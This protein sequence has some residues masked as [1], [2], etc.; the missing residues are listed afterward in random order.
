MTPPA[1][2][3]TQLPHPRSALHRDTPQIM[4]STTHHQKGTAMNSTGQHTTPRSATGLVTLLAAFLCFAG[5]GASLALPASAGAFASLEG[6]PKFSAAPGLPDGREYVQV[7]PADKNG[8]EAGAST[9]VV[10]TGAVDHYGLASTDGNAV[11]FEGTGPMGESPSGANKWF[12]ATK[13]A[14]E[15]GWSTRSLLPAVES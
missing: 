8:N 4:S 12:V 1:F 6:P 9:T 14:G 15:P 3:P 10:D 2:T 7:S 11:L 13:K 5:S